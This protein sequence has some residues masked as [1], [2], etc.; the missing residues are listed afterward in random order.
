MKFTKSDYVRR[1][2]NCTPVQLVVINYELVLDY[3]DE[4]KQQLQQGNEK[5]F[6]QNLSV[7][8]NLMNEL[9]GSLNMSLEI[10]WEL[11]SLYLFVNKL[12]AQAA[13]SNDPQHLDD[14]EKILNNLLVGWQG[15]VDQETDK[16]PVIENSQQVYAGL[17]YGRGGLD[18]FIPTDVSRGFKA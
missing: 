10:S 7:A 3:I 15:L 8:Q 1:I 4:A 11:I 2:S 12:L 16:A 14:A 18:E 17:T 5:K 9:T 13:A 6:R